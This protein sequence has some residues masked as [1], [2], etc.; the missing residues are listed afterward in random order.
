VLAVFFNKLFILGYREV[1]LREQASAS[2]EA[3]EKM[4]KAQD[5]AIS[6]L[7]QG[8]ERREVSQLTWGAVTLKDICDKMATEKPLWTDS[9]ITEVQ[10][11]YERGRQGTIL[12]FPDWLARQTP[13]S[14]AP[15]AVGDFKHKML[16]IV[17]GNL[18]KL[19]LETQFQ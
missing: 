6:K 9:Q 4:E 5:E 13:R 3:I 10:P 18:K 15:E 16:H 14:D 2:V 11:Y 7:E 19:E 12:F 8:V 1:H 17:G